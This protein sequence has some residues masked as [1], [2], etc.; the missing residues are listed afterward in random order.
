MHTLKIITYFPSASLYEMYLRCCNHASLVALPS[1]NLLLALHKYAVKILSPFPMSEET[2]RLNA[3]ARYQLW[4]A[5]EVMVSQLPFW[6]R[7]SPGLR[8]SFG[9]EWTAQRLKEGASAVLFTKKQQMDTVITVINWL[10]NK[11]QHVWGWKVIWSNPSAQARPHR[12]G[13]LVPC[14]DSF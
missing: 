12:A 1:T 9:C 14:P 13:C 10:N 6:P 4:A 5:P 11:S 2:V 8:S 7:D 3:V